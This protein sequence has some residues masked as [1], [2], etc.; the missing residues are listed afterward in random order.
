MYLLKEAS[1]SEIQKHH[2]YNGE[3]K[4]AV[5]S[6]KTYQVWEIIFG[7]KIPKHCVWRHILGCKVWSKAMQSVGGR[8]RHVVAHYGETFSLS[9]SS[10]NVRP[11]AKLHK[12][13]HLTRG[14]LVHLILSSFQPDKL[15]SWGQVDPCS[16]GG[17]CP[18]FLHLS[19]AAL[20]KFSLQ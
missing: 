19:L 1:K 18:T 5:S 3:V 13:P 11:L 10:C 16:N 8:P 20:Q 17:L 15:C 12:P 2:Y 7:C 14:L 4:T 6:C 9:I